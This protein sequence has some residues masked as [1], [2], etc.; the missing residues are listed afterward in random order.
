MLPWAEY[1]INSHT[2]PACGL[3]PFECCLGH[4]PPL[5]PSQE[6]EVGVPTV[7]DVLCLAHGGN[8]GM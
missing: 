1:A 2:S 5:F 8:V 3:S 6:E 4:Q 7:P